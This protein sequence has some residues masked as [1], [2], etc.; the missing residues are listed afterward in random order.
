MFRLKPERRSAQVVEA[1]LALYIGSKL[2]L[3][4]GEGLKGVLTGVS[5]IPYSE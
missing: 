2:K 1:D 3:E 4:Q 5:F